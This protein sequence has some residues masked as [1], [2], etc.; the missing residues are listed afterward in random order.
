MPGY[1]KLKKLGEK[2]SRS[3]NKAAMDEIELACSSD[4]DDKYDEIH[5]RGSDLAYESAGKMVFETDDHTIV[6]KEIPQKTTEYTK[7]F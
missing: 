1:V 3:K 4:D 2:K 6:A 7:F 5:F